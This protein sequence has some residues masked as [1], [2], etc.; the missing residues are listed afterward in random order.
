MRYETFN[1]NTHDTFKVAELT[2]EVDFRT[3]DMLYKSKES[4]VKA[5]AKDLPK[6]G[7][8]DYLKVILDDDGEI[9]GMLMVYTSKTR[10]RFYL[11]PLRLIIVDILDH[12]VL[13]DIEDDDLYLAELAIDPKLRGHGLGRK[14]VCDVIDYARSKNYNRVTIDA[15]FRNHG[16]KRLYER[17]GFK[18]FNKKRVKFLNFERGMFNMEYKLDF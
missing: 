18:V 17:I 9:I 1:S 2:Y 7:L 16:A 4:A 11:R 10:H 8:G 5:I 14:V 15:D 6:R 13:S 3:F 12:F